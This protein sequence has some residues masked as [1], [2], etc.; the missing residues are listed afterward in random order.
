[1]TKGTIEIQAL[2]NDQILKGGMVEMAYAEK[3]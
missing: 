2:R 3:G 1:M